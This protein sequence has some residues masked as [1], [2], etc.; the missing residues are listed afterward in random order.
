MG[1]SQD[2]LVFRALAD[3]TRRRV[4][5][6]LRERPRT[7]GDL[8]GVFAR[9]MTRFAVMKHL[10]V[11][12]RAG[13]VVTRKDGREVWNH[14]NAVP[15]RR[16]YERWVSEAAGVTASGLLALKRAVEQRQSERDE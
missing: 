13:L 15:L 6:L 8:S 12:K 14:I 3:S 16:V 10:G 4:L 2:D 9:D 1:R 11:L 5:D 7:V